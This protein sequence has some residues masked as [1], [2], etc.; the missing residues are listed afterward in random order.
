MPTGAM[1]AA[2]T[3]S[4]RGQLQRPQGAVVR[5]I[6]SFK[7]RALYQHPAHRL[8][9]DATHADHVCCLHLS[10]HPTAATLPYFVKC[11]AQ[12]ATKP[13]VTSSMAWLQHN[14]ILD[15]TWQKVSRQV[16][17]TVARVKGPPQPSWKLHPASS[18]NQRRIALL[19]QTYHPATIKLRTSP[20]NVLYVHLPATG[21]VHIPSQHGT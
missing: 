2:H 3:E 21:R 9:V 13:S 18:Q 11:S 16:L 15:S 12:H 5:S 14:T 7:D 4:I 20:R 19:P 8:H 17:Q 6:C 10:H 1:Q